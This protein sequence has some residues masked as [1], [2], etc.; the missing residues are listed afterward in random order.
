MWFS[1]VTTWFDS[2]FNWA[3]VSLNA[4]II[5]S[6]RWKDRG[7]KRGGVLI[8]PS[9]LRRHLQTKTIN[10]TEQVA[11]WTCENEWENKSQR[12]V[13]LDPVL[14]VYERWVD[15]PPTLTPLWDPLQGRPSVVHSAV[16]HATKLSVRGL[17][18]S[19]SSSR[20]L[21]LPISSLVCLYLIH[22][23]PSLAAVFKFG[24]FS[25]FLLPHILSFFNSLSLSLFLLGFLTS[26]L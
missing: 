9:I 24:S 16:N 7:G 21:S 18:P 22:L 11:Q 5:M 26:W 4:N 13:P 17:G 12:P 3:K 19:L 15:N 10:K 2:R 8:Y 23:F 20:L 14:G 1:W 6:A 25:A